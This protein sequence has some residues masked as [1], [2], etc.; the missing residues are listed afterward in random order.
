MWRCRQR[1][2][3]REQETGVHQHNDGSAG[4]REEPVHTSRYLHSVMSFSAVIRPI[5]LVVSGRDSSATCDYDLY[6]QCNRRLTVS[7]WLFFCRGPQVLLFHC[8]PLSH[9]HISAE[10]SCVRQGLVTDKLSIEVRFIYAALHLLS[11][12]ATQRRR[13]NGTASI[14]PITVT[15]SQNTGRQQVSYIFPARDYKLNHSSR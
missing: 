9:D 12:A 1:D 3:Q 11:P 14:H 4:R 7:L 6:F 2:L 5:G 10:K 13:V 8:R 15:A